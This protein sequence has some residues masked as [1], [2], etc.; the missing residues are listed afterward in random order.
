MAGAINVRSKFNFW[1]DAESAMFFLRQKWNKK[2]LVTIDVS[3]KTKFTRELLR[4]SL[5]EDPNNSVRK[6]M[7]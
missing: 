4:D 7:V 5:S 6:W 2:T 1:W 3:E